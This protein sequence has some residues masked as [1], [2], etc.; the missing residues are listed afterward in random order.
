LEALT[1]TWLLAR[2]VSQS[3]PRVSCA[4]NLTFTLHELDL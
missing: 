4:Q 1:S 3:K 2:G